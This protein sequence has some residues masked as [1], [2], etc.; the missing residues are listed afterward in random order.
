VAEAFYASLPGGKGLFWAMFVI[1]TAAA[2]VASQALI[3]A[4]FAIVSQV[5]LCKPPS[6]CPYGKQLGWGWQSKV[7][8][9][10][11]IR[12]CDVLQAITQSF[13]PHFRVVHTSKKHSGQ[14]Y[15]HV[16][17]NTCGHLYSFMLGCALLRCIKNV[18]MHM[19][20]HSLICSD[21]NS[22]D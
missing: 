14:I 3:S 5:N 6:A 15:V 8:N 7:V 4:T 13:F 21:T 10:G 12:S 17:N 19:C 22:A 11:F 16:V 20:P 1:A 9:R 2:I 18:N